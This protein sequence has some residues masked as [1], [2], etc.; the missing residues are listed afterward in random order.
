MNMKQTSKT[1]AGSKNALKEL[2]HTLQEAGKLPPAK[3]QV[4]PYEKILERENNCNP[5]QNALLYMSLA[6]AKSNAVSQK[7]LLL[8]SLEFIKK[9]K[10][11]EDTLAAITL[12]N[13]VQISAARF[14]H[15]YFKKSPDLVHPFNLLANPLYIKKSTVPYTPIL[16]GRTST[17]ITM[18]L[19]FFK[20]ITEYK[21]WRQIG[22]TALYGKPSGSGV[23]VSLNN[24]DYEGTGK[25][26]KPGEIVHVTGLIPN[27]NYVFA[28]G[29]FT[30]D[31][32]CVNGIGETCKEILTLLPLPVMQI[33]GYLAEIAF[34][35]GQYQIAK[36]A[37][38]T[39]CSAFVIKNEF[40]YSFLDARVNPILAV[41]LNLAYFNL[42]SPIEAKQLAE[43]FIILA[44]VSK[45]LKNDVQKRALS[46]ELKIE[47]QK[48]DM[49]IANYLLIA[50][51]IGTMLNRP[52]L[53]K[54]TV[55][56]LFNHLLQYFQMQL[57]SPL[58]LQILVKLH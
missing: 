14:F 42:I 57:Q 45:I 19:P 38:E 13:A 50:L 44:R 52:I 27:E 53:I 16:I 7:S 49:R 8:A 51:D 26:M 39:V 55:C 20:P 3:P 48:M 18:K 11:A 28:A 25:K 32:I 24:T 21:A 6:V 35:L 22:T 30:D 10:E 33:Q 12:E 9:A 56:E 23:A 1:L 15:P 4:L 31:G 46:H 41:R 54:K 29:G 58:L 17:S 5:Y 37:A 47:N 40:K 2:Q 43:D 36:L 34:K